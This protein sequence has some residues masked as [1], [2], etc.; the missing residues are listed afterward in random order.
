MAG[1]TEIVCL[2]AGVWVKALAAEELSD[3]AASML[4]SATGAGRLVAPAFCWAEVGSV[5]LKKARTGQLTAE[6]AADAWCDFQ[7]MD[8]TFID[9]P[10]MQGRA[11]QMAVSFQLPTVYDTAYLACT[12]LAEA[13]SRSFWTADDALLRALG[14]RRPA[15]MHHL[16]ELGR[17]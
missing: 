12:E 6:E 7:A 15:Y 10:E 1:T 16:R 9:T 2:D 5:L 14:E 4:A 11:W 3:E 8:I 13:T 17:G